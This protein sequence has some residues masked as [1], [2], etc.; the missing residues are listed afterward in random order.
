MQAKVRGGSP[1]RRSE[2][3]G[4]GFVKEVGF[5]PGVKERWSYRCTKWWIRR[6]RSDG[7]RNRWVGDGGTGARMRFTKRQ[8]ELIPETRW[9][10]TEGAN[11]RTNER[12]SRTGE[13]TAAGCIVVV[14]DADVG[15]DR[16]AAGGAGWTAMSASPAGTLVH[17]DAVPPRRST[18]P[19]SGHGRRVVRTESRSTPAEVSAGNVDAVRAGRVA[20]RHP[21]HA[22]VHI[23]TGKNGKI[24]PDFFSVRNKSISIV[25]SS[26]TRS[27]PPLQ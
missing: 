19:G 24:L 8:R 20:R 12:T 17:V 25:S 5:K 10:I 7:W 16:V 13:L 22:L 3:K 1:G 23:C 15:A 18:D 11:E 9:S 2:T 26:S 27:P 21:F 6:G 4:V 14:A